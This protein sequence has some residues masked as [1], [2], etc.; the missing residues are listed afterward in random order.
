MDLERRLLRLDDVGVKVEASDRTA[1]VRHQTFYEFL[2][3]EVFVHP[4]RC[5][6]FLIYL[7]LAKLPKWC[8]GGHSMRLLERSSDDR[9]MVGCMEKVVRPLPPDEWWVTPGGNMRTCKAEFCAHGSERSWRSYPCV[10]SSFKNS[11]QAPQM[12]KLM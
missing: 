3:C 2:C 11:V 4:A 7:G 6:Q 1:A 10:S 12:L 5:L 9:V 8:G